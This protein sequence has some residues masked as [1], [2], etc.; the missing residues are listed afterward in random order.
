MRFAK[1]LLMSIGAVALAAMLV[2]VLAPQAV[3]AAVAALVQVSNPAT[4][5][6]LNSRIDDPGRIPYQNTAVCPNTNY[7][8]FV[9]QPVPANHRLVVEHVSAQFESATATAGQCDFSVY[10]SGSTTAQASGSFLMPPSVFVPNSNIS[11]SNQSIRVSVD[12]NEFF[13]FDCRA[14]TT[15]QAAY[16]GVSGYLLDCNAAPCAAIASF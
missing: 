8:Q 6:V 10:V 4:S 5:P 3:H 12:P 15:L 2:N 11:G 7:C 13:S 14:N 1:N 9:P 16:L